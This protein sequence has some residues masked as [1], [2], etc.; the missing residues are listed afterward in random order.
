MLEHPDAR[1]C[2]AKS[3]RTLKNEEQCELGSKRV[4]VLA[5]GLAA[6]RWLPPADFPLPGRTNV[7]TQ[8]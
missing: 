4:S 8:R 1:C 6:R 7:V 2:F 3:V 5:R